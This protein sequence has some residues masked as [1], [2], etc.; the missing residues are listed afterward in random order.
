M[1]D[2]ERRHL[3]RA[4]LLRI[5]LGAW[6]VTLAPGLLGAA[7]PGSQG[8]AGE[9]P[10]VS[11]STLGFSHALS[12][13]EPGHVWL[14]PA[15]GVRIA[16]ASIQ[17]AVDAAQDGDAVLL[18]DGAFRGAGNRGI[19]VSGKNLTIRSQNGAARTILDAEYQARGITFDGTGVTN[20]TV[21]R[22]ITILRGQAPSL[23]GRGGGLATTNDAAPVIEECTIA[24][25]RSSVQGGGVAIG[26]YALSLPVLRDCSVL[27]NQADGDGGGV[28]A[29]N[30]VIERCL[31]AGNWAGEHGGG[32]WTLPTSGSI[33]DCVIAANSARHGG[34]MLIGVALDVSGCT[35]VRNRSRDGNSSGIVL[36]SDPD[37]VMSSTIVWGN[38]DYQGAIGYQ[39]EQGLGVGC[40]RATFRYC[41]IQGGAAAVWGTPL[42]KPVL[43]GITD[44]D[45]LFVAPQAGDYR[46]S[47]DS[48]CIDGGDPLDEPLVNQGDLEVQPRA[49]R[50]VDIGADEFW[51]GLALS[52]IQPG[53]AGEWN[54]VETSGGRAGEL[55]LFFAGVETGRTSLSFGACPELE[56][57]LRQAQFL[58]L[59]RADEDGRASYGQL[60]PATLSG[61]TVYLQAVGF[62]PLAA[63]PLACQVSNVVAFRYP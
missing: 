40:T 3:E 62:E 33:R 5:R 44:E 17:A 22:G 32:L 14:V 56:L 6:L 59:D 7:V 23:S 47:P 61:I 15:G 2:L 24:W 46:L 8:S 35:I 30:V 48:P 31:I 13:L 10:A 58:G 34:G 49:N 54:R 12:A 16:H 53:R 36:W 51:P 55:V 11:G 41:D 45:P 20:E 21:L 37:V 38:L 25:C 52:L 29:G 63:A 26:S 43:I 39:I 42:T 27:D 28:F 1:V 60:V 19:V 57:G 4:N 18:S 9:D 50:H